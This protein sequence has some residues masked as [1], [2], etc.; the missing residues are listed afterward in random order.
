VELQHG[1]LELLREALDAAPEPGAVG[2]RLL[3]PD[4]SLQPSAHELPTV[5][6]LF[7]EALFLDRL[8]LVGDRL[9]YHARGYDYREPRTVGWL[10]GAALLVRGSA[11]QACGGFDPDFFFFVEEVD[12]QRRL[13]ALGWSVVIEPRAA[14][15][16]HG[17]KQP[18]E[19]EVFLHSHEGFARYFAKHDGPLHSRLA[20]AALCLAA[21]T[22]ALA[23]AVVPLV[24]PAA[25][26]EARRWRAMFWKVFT[27]S[28]R[29][30]IR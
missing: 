6:A 9:G 14:V 19:P 1:A 26:G 13:H 3:E 21:L 22:R 4:G 17:G 11:W 16:H 7:A 23:W 8:P 2:P 5:G 12:L 30:L 28:A 24:R 18:L 27:R 25:A 15:V 10:T 29:A 20:R